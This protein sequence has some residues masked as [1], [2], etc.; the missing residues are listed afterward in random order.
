MQRTGKSRSV[1]LIMSVLPA[2]MC[3]AFSAS[4]SVAAEDGLVAHW[5]FDDAR[6]DKLTDSSGNGNHGK[7][8]GPKWGKG[9]SGGALEFDGVDDFVVIPKSV[10]LDSANRQITVSA[11]IKTPLE[12]RHT[13]LGRMLYEGRAN[14]RSMLLEV[15]GEKKVASFAVSPGGMKSIWCTASDPVVPKDEWVHVVGVSNGRTMSLFVNGRQCASRDDAPYRVFAAK[16]DLYIGI[17]RYGKDKSSGPFKGLIDEVKIYSRAMNA[18]EVLKV[19]ADFGPKG[20]VSGKVTDAKGKTIKQ[21]IVHIGLFCANTGADGTY[22]LEVPPGKY[23]LQAFKAGY[24][25][26][27]IDVQVEKDKTTMAATVSMTEDKVK[28][29][30]SNISVWGPTSSVAVVEWETNEPCAGD[31]VCRLSPRTRDKALIVRDAPYTKSHRV[32]LSGLKPETK[33]RFWILNHDLAGNGVQSKESTFTTSLDHAEKGLVAY[34]KFDAG[35]GAMIFDASGN[36]NHGYIHGNAAWSKGRVGGGLRLDGKDDYVRIP[37]CASLDSANKE[38]TL[39]AWIKTPLTQRSTIFGRFFYYRK[40]MGQRSVQMDINSAKGAVNFALSPDGRSSSWC[41]SSAQ[42]IP[43][44]EWVHVA[45]VSDGKIMNTYVNGRKDIFTAISPAGGIH[46]SELDL[47]IGAWYANGKFGC[48]FDGIIDEARIYSRALSEA[49]ILKVYAD[50]C[51]KG[52]ISGEVAD[53]DGR[54]VVNAKISWGQFSTVSGKNGAYDITVPVGSYKV[55]VTRKGYKSVVANYIVSEGKAAKGRIVLTKDDTGPKILKMNTGKTAN[56]TALIEWETDERAI[57]T[58]SYG[59]SAGKFT[60]KAKEPSGVK[61]HRVLLTGLKPATKYHFAVECTDEAGNTTKSKDFSFTTK[62]LPETIT[63]STKPGPRDKNIGPDVPLGSGKLA[64]RITVKGF[65]TA[66]VQAACDKAAA[67]G[68]PVVYL[69]AGKYVIKGVNIPAGLTLLG[70]G[71]KTYISSVKNGQIFQ[72][73]G[74]GVRLTRMKL[75][76]MNPTFANVS[77]SCCLRAFNVKNIRVDHC[78]VMAFARALYFGKGAIGQVDHCIIHHNC[79]SGLGYGVISVNDGTMVLIC[80]NICHSNRH[81]VTSN[82][83]TAH[84]MFRYNHVLDVKDCA[85]GDNLSQCDVHPATTDD[86]AFVVEY[87]IFENCKGALGCWRGRGVVRG[88]VFRNLYYAIYVTS[89]VPHEVNNNT[90]EKVR[91]SY[92]KGGVISGECKIPRP[93]DVP[94]MLEMDVTGVIQIFEKDT[95]TYYTG[96]GK[97]PRNKI[98]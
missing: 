28:P 63:W 39:T 92:F 51:P 24:T 82:Y 97:A 57:S 67:D 27:L 3:V 94:H 61:Y 11:W 95:T 34:W 26:Q 60:S 85:K 16:S 1:R 79:W 44:D 43:K 17:W 50:G 89:K 30:I 72:A 21:A 19:Y 35:K 32:I 98:R 78:E 90:F 96:S 70:A 64:N 83:G 71:S 66:D 46:P 31:V 59:T 69:P 22:S 68:V 91:N 20:K 14:D 7:I 80:D 29:E 42:V 81:T 76:G 9:I 49:E 4:C 38:I 84:Y 65:T 2:F 23:K 41:S 33:Y 8:H 73:I 6:G 62:K 10:S 55:M 12:A 88:N 56:Y 25:R 87:N 40:A 5:K 77:D 54:P 36:Q 48:L 53:T 45:A 37:K 58:V 15:R 75:Y 74:D 86:G 52:M 47:Y 13:I 18:D 93:I